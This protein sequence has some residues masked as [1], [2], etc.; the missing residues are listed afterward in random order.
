MSS[1]VPAAP[2]DPTTLVTSSRAAHASPTGTEDVVVDELELLPVEGVAAVLGVVALGDEHAARVTAATAVTTP[3]MTM[4][5]RD[6][7]RD[8][9]RHCAPPGIVHRRDRCG[10][11]VFRS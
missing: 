7:D 10:V 11:E 5:E 4:P 9:D 6:R 1:K 8:R 3:A 2:W